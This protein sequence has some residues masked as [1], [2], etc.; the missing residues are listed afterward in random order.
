M[1]HIDVLEELL[2]RV[3]R[4]E[5]VTTSHKNRNQKE[6]ADYLSM[7]VSKLRQLH[8]EG[9]GPKRVTIGRIHHYRQADLDEFLA[10][11]E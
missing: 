7:S 6:A 11:E 5:R 9:R 2:T 1:I 8:R 3:R 10:T 4:L